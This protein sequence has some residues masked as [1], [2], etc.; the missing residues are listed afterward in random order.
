MKILDMQPDSGGKSKRSPGRTGCYGTCAN[1]Y[2][3]TESLAVG[4]IVD[5]M[6]IVNRL[7]KASVVITI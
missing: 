2:Q 1:C 3:L 4:S 5:M 6:N 7:A